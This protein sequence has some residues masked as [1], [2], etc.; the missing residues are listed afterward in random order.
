MDCFLSILLSC[1]HAVADSCLCSKHVEEMMLEQRVLR[2]AIQNKI[3]VCPSIEVRLLT[4]LK[5]NVFCVV[6]T[7]LLAENNNILVL[8]LDPMNTFLSAAVDSVFSHSCSVLL[9]NFPTDFS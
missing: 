6:L 8:S 5:I 7:S 2:V 3:K 9:I 4:F 1:Q